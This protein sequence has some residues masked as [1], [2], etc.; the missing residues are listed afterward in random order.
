MIKNHTNYIVNN[1]DSNPIYQ[2]IK[3]Y[4]LKKKKKLL[5]NTYFL[6]NY[7]QLHLIL[8]ICFTLSNILLLFFKLIM[9]KDKD[10]NFFLLSEDDEDDI[11]SRIK[12][13]CY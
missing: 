1:I 7:K 6:L 9:R 10:D 11:I 5:K 8:W 3:K 2:S 13:F 12:C 4:F